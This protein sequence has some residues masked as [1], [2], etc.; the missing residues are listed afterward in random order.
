TDTEIQRIEAILGWLEANPRSSLYPRQLPIA[1][2]DTKWLENRKGLIGDLFATLSTD[3]NTTADF[4]EC[5]GLRRTP[6]LVRV[7]ILDKDIRK[8]VGG[9]GDISAPADE[10]AK[11]DMPV[12]HAFIVENLQTGLAF[13]DIPE[14]VVFMRLGYDVEVLSRMTWLRGARCIYW[15]D[16]DTH[17]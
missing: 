8:Y 14:S 10:L 6:Y 13:D 17:G 4:F 12:R 1:G 15:G 16:I 11:L 9:I 3:T 2:V 7:R 5:C